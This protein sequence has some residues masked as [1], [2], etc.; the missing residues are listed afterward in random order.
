M[1]LESASSDVEFDS[2]GFHPFE[3]S[4]GIEAITFELFFD[5]LREIPYRQLYL[6]ERLR[7]TK[8]SIYFSD[9]PIGS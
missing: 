9:D 3:P 8:T 1:I 6:G 4:I 2:A 7:C 5:M